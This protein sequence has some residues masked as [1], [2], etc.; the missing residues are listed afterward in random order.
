MGYGTS[1]SAEAGRR[2][3]LWRSFL[4]VL[5]LLMLGCAV[6]LYSDLTSTMK[7]G[8]RSRPGPDSGINSSLYAGMYFLLVVPAT[9]L[10]FYEPLRRKL[11]VFGL[12]VVIGLIVSNHYAI[13]LGSKVE[14][15]RT[16]WIGFCAAHTCI[17]PAFLRHRWGDPIE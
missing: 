1:K 5:W 7:I 9:W 16:L 8:P 2:H 17:V 15:R 10:A 11:P 12:G 6:L 14:L 4:A 3:P 13:E